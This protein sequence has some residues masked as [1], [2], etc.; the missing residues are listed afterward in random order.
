MRNS[1]AAAGRLIGLLSL[2]VAASVVAGA[3]F[4]GLFVPAVAAAGGATKGSIT[5]FND[6]KAVPPIEDLSQASVLLAADGRTTIARF[7]A[8]NRQTVP[9]NKISKNM[10][11]SII[12]IEDSRFRD[13]GGVDPIGLVRAAV[14]DY[15]GSGSQVQGASTLTQQYI[16]NLYVEQAARRGDKAA[17]QAATAKDASRKILEIRA[18]I[19]LEKTMSKDQILANYLNIAFFGNQAYG[20]EAA[21]ERYFSIH[22][23]QLSIEQSAL[24]AGVVNA[25]FTFDPINKKKNALERRNIV[26][27]R[28]HELKVISDQQY[29]KAVK[30]KIVLK[31]K[32][33]LG[34]CITAIEGLGYFCE[35]V[36]Q[37]VAQGAD[38][39]AKLGSTRQARLDALDRGGLKITSTID[40]DTQQAALK[41]IKK[42]VP[43]GDRSKVA[44]AAVTVEP[45]TGHVL[46]MAQNKKFNP[47]SSRDQTEINYSVDANLG[48]SAGFQ[49]GSTFKAFTLATWL[50]DGRDLNARINASR[51]SIPVRDFIRCGNSHIGPSTE[52]YNFNNS[53]PS[54][55][56]NLSVLQATAG[57]VNT[58]FVNMEQQLPLCDISKT[59][60]GMGV[61]LAGPASDCGKA[62]TDVPD[63]I[64]SMTLGPFS[65]S[66]LTM[67]SAYATFAAEGTYC[68]PFPV[69]GIKDADGNGIP[70]KVPGCD[71]QA[72]DPEV[73]RGVTYALKGVLTHGTA[74]NVNGRVP[75]HV[76]GKTGTT[77]N[78]VDTWF[79]G[80]TKQRTT[81]VWVG[82]PTLYKH[83]RT[84]ARRS[85]NHR[86]I[87]GTQYGTVFG[88]T[89]SAPIWAGIMKSAVQGTDTSDWPSPPGSMLGSEGSTA[90][91]GSDVPDVTGK[92]IGEAFGILA[93]AGLQPRVGGSVNSSVPAG[94]V[95][96]TDPG[97][98]SSASDGDTVTIHP[99]NGRGGGGNGNGNGNRNGHHRKRPKG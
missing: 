72:L 91:A 80:Y 99:S 31:P 5:W 50:R 60:E 46:A 82:D 61:H 9:L 25:P 69:L 23:S 22:A 33:P 73:A 1:S 94:F 2:F 47:S 27:T 59:A 40:L 4:A 3:L 65:I 35:Y 92:S 14:S 64:P 62:S 84:Y 88:A 55:G 16:K 70:I 32:V 29:A 96:S 18:A 12:A 51:K 83:G 58:A 45:N 43:I 44:T 81:A 89:I 75:G 30:S 90:S 52:I 85:L 66:P 67:A 20:I 74:T 10:Q 54:E 53:E 97:A 28:M 8:E 41:S 6:L 11:N 21:A 34:G 86:K 68:P 19:D 42:Y 37:M 56:G 17:V 63:C 79:V 77:N 38:A 48:G 49:T 36:R 26:L 7:Y 39:F 24:L 98:G 76:A 13:H 87:G 15:L 95:A 71:K 93:Q 78:S 57:S